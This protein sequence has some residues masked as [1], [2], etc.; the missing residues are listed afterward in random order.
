MEIDFNDIGLRK[1]REINER[2]LVPNIT[3]ELIQL[4]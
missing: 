1:M 3:E 4:V 2:N